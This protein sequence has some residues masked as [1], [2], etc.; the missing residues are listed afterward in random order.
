V[1]RIALPRVGKTIDGPSGP[2]S[3]AIWPRPQKLKDESDAAL[4]GL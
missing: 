2:R 1:S 4:K 3:Q